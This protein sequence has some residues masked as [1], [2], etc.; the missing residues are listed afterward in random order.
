MKKK[1][2]RA[3]IEQLHDLVAHQNA[4]ISRRF[5]ENERLEDRIQVYRQLLLDALQRND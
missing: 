4:Q 2:L 1:T 3:E 5:E